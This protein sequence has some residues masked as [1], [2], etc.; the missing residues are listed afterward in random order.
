MYLSPTY[1]LKLYRNF[2]ALEVNDFY[3]VVRYYEQHEE[4]LHALEMEEY[5]DCTLTY[6]NALYETAD[7]ARHN[8]MCDH[9]LELTMA[10]GLD[11]WGGEDLFSQLLLRKSLALYHSGDLPQATHI[12][13]QLVRIRPDDAVARHLYLNCLLRQRPK[14]LLYVRA[15][16]LLL[17]L[18]AAVGVGLVGVVVQAFFPDWFVVGW[19]LS[20][21]LL[22]LGLGLLL[23]GELWHFWRCQRLCKH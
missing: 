5:L 2:K 13:R 16:A 8:V 12:L 20:G 11:R 6:A 15:V 18:V 23:G 3:G 7:Y 14:V 9:L 4:A 22:A 19:W 10:E 21:G 17:I 1:R